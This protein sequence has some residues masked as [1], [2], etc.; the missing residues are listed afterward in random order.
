MKLDYKYEDTIGLLVHSYNNYLSGLIGFTELAILES[1][2][3]EVT[4]KLEVALESGV[5]AVTFGKQ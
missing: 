1:R 3:D 4:E 5:D 2:Q